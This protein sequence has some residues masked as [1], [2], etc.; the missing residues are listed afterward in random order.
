VTRAEALRALAVAC[1]RARQYEEAAAAWRSILDL[2][3]CPSSIYREATEALAVHHEHRL[4]DPL[5]ARSFA[6]RSLRL[7]VTAT[8]R[9]AIEHR[10]ARLNRKIDRSGPEVAQLF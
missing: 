7:P 9:E 1:R 3:G 4:R 6:L 10:L 2:R 8:R 5:S